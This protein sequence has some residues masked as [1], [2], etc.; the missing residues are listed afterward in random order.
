MHTA[1]AADPAHCP[2]MYRPSPPSQLPGWR[3]LGAA[4]RLMSKTLQPGGSR[5]RRA[6]RGLWSPAC[7]AAGATRCEWGGAG[8]GAQLR[9]PR[10]RPDITGSDQPARQGA[11]LAPALCS[12]RAPAMP[13]RMCLHATCRRLTLFPARTRWQSRSTGSSVAPPPI[14]GWAFVYLRCCWLA[15]RGLPRGQ[16]GFAC[17]ALQA[18]VGHPT[19]PRLA[20]P[21]AGVGLRAGGAA[22]RRRPPGNSV[23]GAGKLRF[24]CMP[25]APIAVLLWI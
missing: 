18:A 6:R 21:C 9:Q 16:L 2:R 23:P 22:G 12:Q 8:G 24:S 10:S 19:P 1:T 14:A 20:A 25:Q 4:G 11:A 5:G 3:R 7:L 13:Q 17:L 15:C